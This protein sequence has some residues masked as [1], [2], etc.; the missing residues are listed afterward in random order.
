VCNG[1]I[2]IAIGALAFAYVDGSSGKV[3]AVVC[4]LCSLGLFGVSRRLRRDN[5]WDWPSA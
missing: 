2:L 3:V 5:E 4:W 1:L